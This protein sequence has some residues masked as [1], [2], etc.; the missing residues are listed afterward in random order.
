MKW[1]AAAAASCISASWPIKLP[2]TNTQFVRVSE[3]LFEC[4][5]ESVSEGLSDCLI[6]LSDLSVCL[7]VHRVCVWFFLMVLSVCLIVLSVCLIVSSW[8]LFSLLQGAGHSEEKGAELASRSTN[9]FSQPQPA[10]PDWILSASWRSPGARGQT[11]PPESA[12]EPT[13]PV[14]G[15]G[16]APVSTSLS[17]F[18]Y[19]CSYVP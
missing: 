10:G 5:S 17:A 1:S 16:Q 12:E 8:Y 18:I 13:E 14:P 7:I 11:E 19:S 2:N 6:A 15:G 4:L 3:C 9:R